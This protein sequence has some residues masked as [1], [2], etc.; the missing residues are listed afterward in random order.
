MTELQNVILT[1]YH[2][3]AQIHA[4]TQT[5]NSIFENTEYLNK[6][7]FEGYVVDRVTFRDSLN[8]TISNYTIILYC[9]FLEEY[10]KYFSPKHLGKEYEERLI[11]VRKKNTPV[12]KRTNQW[13]D[14]Y[15]FRNQMVAHN[16]RIK[17]KSFFS[18]EFKELEYQIPNTNSEKNLMDGIIYL[19]CLN[20]RL[21]FPEVIETL[22]PDYKMIFKLKIKSSIIDHEKELTELY[23]KCYNI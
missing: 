3:Q 17:N 7:K 6:I 4:I 12:I 21:E 1:L 8:A 9:S 19:L 10:N 15:E 5:L 13:K 2:L 22:N 11:K 18:E 20:I 23:E 16:F 14:L